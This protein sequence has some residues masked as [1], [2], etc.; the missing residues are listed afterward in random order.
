MRRTSLVVAAVLLA[1]VVLGGV[2]TALIAPGDDAE[3]DATP[4]QLGRELASTTQYELRVEQRR[5]KLDGRIAVVRVTCKNEKYPRFICVADV[6]A[7]GEVAR[8]RPANPTIT[9]R[10]GGGG[11]WVVNSWYDR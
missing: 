5:R 1:L 9:G 6:A 10:H 7:T 3:A 4:D 2:A 11:G 8:L